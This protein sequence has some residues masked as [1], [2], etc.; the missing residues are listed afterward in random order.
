MNNK[1]STL[2]ALSLATFFSSGV[3]A[4]ESY[5]PANVCQL[6]PEP[7]Q[8]WKGSTSR[9]NITNDTAHATG[10]SSEY[11]ADNANI[12]NYQQNWQ[13]GANWDNLRVGFDEGGNSWQLYKKPAASS[14]NGYGCF[15]AD[16]VSGDGVEVGKDGLVESRKAETPTNITPNFGSLSL[17]I[18]PDKTDSWFFKKYKIEEFCEDNPSICRYESRRFRPKEAEVTVLSSLKSLTINN[19]GASFDK[20]TVVIAD[21]V[22]VESVNIS[23]GDN[24]IFQ[25]LNNSTVTFG[26]WKEATGATVYFFGNNSRINIVNSFNMANKMKVAN[27]NSVTLYAPTGDINFST[28]NDNFYGFVLGKTVSFEN[29]ITVH[30]AVTSQ[31]LTMKHNVVIQKPDYSCA[32]P[33]PVQQCSLL[34]EE[35][36]NSGSLSNWSVMGFGTSDEPHIS[37]GRFIL[38]SNKPEQATASAY[39]YIFPSDQNYLEIEFD[40][41]AYGGNGADGVALVISDASVP[42]QT[43]AFGGPLGYGM[44]LLKNHYPEVSKDVEGFAGGWLGIGI[45]EFGNYIREGSEKIVSNSV[46]D[47]VGVRGQGVQ[48]AN[49]KWLKGYPYI[50]GKKYS[51]SLDNRKGKEKLH[52]YKVVLNS[53]NTDTITLAVFRK[54]GKNGGWDPVIE[55][56]NVLEKGGFNYIPDNFRLSVTASTGMLTNTHDIDNF[57]VCADKYSRL[58]DGIH[59]FE[60]DYSGSGSTC[61]ASDVTLRACMNE[62]CSEQYPRDA[63]DDGSLTPLS[64]TLLP[65]TGNNVANWVG[66]TNVQFENETQLELQGSRAGD[67]TLGIDQSSVPQFGFEG[68]RCRINGGPLS[69]NNCNVTFASN[70]LAVNVNDVVASRETTGEDYLSFCSTRTE[71]GGESR[72]VNMSIDYEV[73]PIDSSQPVVISYKKKVKDQAVEWSSNVELTRANKYLP[74]VYF[75]DEGKAF[76]KL[77]YSEAGKVKLKASV[78]GVDDSDGFG[79]FVSFPS[80]LKVTAKSGDKSGECTNS[81]NGC[82]SG[83]VAAGEVFELTISALQDDDTVAEN[84]QEKTITVSNKVKYPSNGSLAK[85]LNEKLPESSKWS[86]GSVTFDQSVSEVGVFE[87]I[88]EAPVAKDENGD[89]IGTSLY[90]GSNAFKIADGKSTIGRFYPDYFKVTGTEWTYPDNQNQSVYMGQN[91]ESVKFEVTAYNA[92]GYTTQNYGGFANSLKADLYLAG[93]YSDRLSILDSDLTS[94]NWSGAVWSKTWDN[95]VYWRKDLSLPSPDGPF[96]SK[97]PADKDSSIETSISLSLNNNGTKVSG[98]VD[99]TMFLKEGQNSTKDRM[100]SQQL[101]SQPDVRFGRIALDDVGVNQG[102]S[103]NIPLRVEY[104][105]DTRFVLNSKDNGTTV[106]PTLKSQEPVWPDDGSDCDILLEGVR[107][108]VNDGAMRELIAKQERADCGRQQAEVWLNL[109]PSGNNLP[110]LK[111]DWDND[112][113]EE[114]PSSVVTFGIHRGNDRVI[115]RGEPGLTGQ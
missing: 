97:L 35:N 104:W 63:Y 85:L 98:Y 22:Q 81:E 13:G 20:L 88:A 94:D 17:D 76:F 106:S 112:G 42:P 115:Y 1:K 37:D 74:N 16:G 21:G 48:D 44:K 91:F 54:V 24:V 67:I 66:G 50:T 64:V 100:V 114:N 2:V 19:Y 47:N 28:A 89:D 72:G 68:A 61:Q 23:R 70:V 87:L 92:N 45:D 109:D 52:R 26:N 105:R 33:P 56:F 93:G 69:A 51:S 99:P 6:F 111:Y 27:T 80:K 79:S 31:N 18:N 53:R 32:P 43:G 78:E 103:V 83:F 9:L 84:Y 95:S 14:C 41:N 40:H 90:L 77:R 113:S 73:A 3:T 29:P 82:S 107:T 101:L 38:N 62:S 15:P 5:L 110:W 11:L 34:P 7:I 59:H 55:E 39:N 49:G 12:Y 57:R 71:D 46:A 86:R 108:T 65:S 25:T 36:F 96:N 58:T 102:K 4:L 60:F 30:G 8:G 75:D 10:W